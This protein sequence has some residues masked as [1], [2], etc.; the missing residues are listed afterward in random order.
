MKELSNKINV[1]I[2]FEETIED[3][4]DI[5]DIKKY[6]RLKLITNGGESLSGKKLIEDARKI[7]HSNFVCLVFARNRDHLKWILQME[8][9][10]LLMT[11]IILKSLLN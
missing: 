6:N 5:I 1:N 9:F 10:F 3:A 8:I 4:I 2:Y 7:L 11:L